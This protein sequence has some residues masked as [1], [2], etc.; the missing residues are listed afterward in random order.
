MTEL[1][2]AQ[3][4]VVDSIVAYLE[5]NVEDE[6]NSRNS[7]Y[8]ESLRFTFKDYTY[9]SS[10]NPLGVDVYPLI[11]VNIVDDEQVVKEISPSGASG[12]WKYEIDLDIYDNR[13]LRGPSCD[14]LE[15]LHRILL[16]HTEA[17]KRS[18]QKEIGLTLGNRVRSCRV[19]G[20]VPPFN[21]QIQD[22]LGKK[23]SIDVTVFVYIS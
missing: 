21:I 3:D 12:V 23:A 15:N 2:N 8:D 6:Y 22:G 13:L 9:K 1:S 16:R 11:V 5:E 18:L 19:N 14:N 7:A 17:V 4:H 20:S 10:F